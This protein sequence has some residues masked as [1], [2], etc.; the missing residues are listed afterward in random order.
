[1]GQVW[2]H[3]PPFVRV[4]GEWIPKAGGGPVDYTGHVTVARVAGPLSGVRGVKRDAP[5]AR[6]IPVAFDAKVADASSAI[7]HHEQK[8]QHQLHALREASTAGSAAFLLVLMPQLDRPP[9]RVFAID[10][11]AHFTELLSDG[12]RLFEPARRATRTSPRVEPFPLLPSIALRGTPAI[13]G[14][15]WIP[16][17]EWITNGS[18]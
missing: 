4:K 11:V 3:S 6:V 10:V 18:P 8:R 13:V 7:Y 2:P 15:D 5:G 12:L 14:W 9:G 16:L 1:M 17:L